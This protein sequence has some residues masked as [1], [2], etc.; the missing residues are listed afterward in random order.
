MALAPKL[1][2]R[3]IRKFERKCR[4]RVN[5]L[6]ALTAAS[7]GIPARLYDLNSDGGRYRI[8]YVGPGQPWTVEVVRAPPKKEG[9][10]KKAAKKAAAKKTAANAAAT[11]KAAARRVGST[12]AQ[13]RPNSAPAVGAVQSGQRRAAASNKTAGRAPRSKSGKPPAK[14]LISPGPVSDPPDKP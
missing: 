2:T 7:A 11:K 3:Q 14:R 6:A 1:K 4:D 9:T 10:K 12:T 8:D 5:Q 13:G